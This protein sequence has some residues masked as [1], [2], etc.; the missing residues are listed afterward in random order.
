MECKASSDLG[1]ARDHIM[2][3]GLVSV[4]H[5][6]PGIGEEMGV[7]FSLGPVF[8]GLEIARTKPC[9]WS[10][11][12]LVEDFT[13]APLRKNNMFKPIALALLSMTTVGATAALAEGLPN[14]N[15]GL[16]SVFDH[17]QRPNWHS[18]GHDSQ[19]NDGDS[20]DGDGGNKSDPPGA[21]AAPEIDPA[22]ALGA[23]TL[24][25]GALTIVRGRRAARK[26]D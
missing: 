10:R 21:P 16:H 15:S 26:A 20:D 25:A 4:S 2:R 11:C 3:N 18:Q 23:L 1:R 17:A 7:S 13:C 12:N 6:A 9:R 5:R 8:L 19:G 24:L 22:G 14:H